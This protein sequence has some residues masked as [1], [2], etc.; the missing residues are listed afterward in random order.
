MALII[1][2]ILIADA[3]D[4]P[5]KQVPEGEDNVPEGDTDGFERQ[6]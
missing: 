3:L 5:T 1:C 6:I 4:D 2:I